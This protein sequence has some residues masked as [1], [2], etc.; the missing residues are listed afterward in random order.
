MKYANF[1]DLHTHSK[2]SF[3]GHHSCTL[4]CESAVQKGLKGLAITDHCEI[5]SKD[6]DFNKLCSSQFFDTSKA[7]TVFSGSL[8]VFKGI[9]LGQAVYDKP[10]AEKI[11]AKYDYDF[12]LGSIHNL[13]DMEDFSFSITTKAMIFMIYSADILIPNTSFVNGINSIRLHI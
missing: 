9:E 12:V 10:L 2:H 6:C 7:A 5:D 1:Y 13:R 3:D 4:M 8:E 11:L